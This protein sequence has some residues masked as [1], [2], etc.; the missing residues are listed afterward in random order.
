MSRTLPAQRL[1]ITIALLVIFF[2]L[3]LL[4]LGPL[5]FRERGDDAIWYFLHIAGG[6]IV[7]A[8]GPF[9]FIAALRNRVRRYHRFAGYLYAGASAAAV[10]GF[11][12]LPKNEL[13]LTSQL[14]VLALWIL[15]VVFAIR[16][17]RAGNVLS[18]QHNM[19]R[20][21]VLACYF[22]TARLVDRYGMDLLAPLAEDRSARFAHSDWLAWLVP[23][24]LV[25]AYF[26]I[27]WQAALRSHRKSASAG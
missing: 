4:I 14:V 21:F 22:L 5:V 12:G 16:A 24:V 2:T 27:R 9:Q 26:T 19:A 10:A 11:A 1:S 7:L 25:E 6:S 8:L 20:S 13:F 3:V 17:I 18:H 15:C 23:L